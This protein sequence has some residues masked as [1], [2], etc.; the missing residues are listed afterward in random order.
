MT[1]GKQAVISNISAWQTW[2]LQ[3]NNTKWHKPNVCCTLP[4]ARVPFT[5]P[6]VISQNQGTLYQLS[7]CHNCY[8]LV[9]Q[10]EWLQACG[11]QHLPWSAQNVH[12][13]KLAAV[14]IVLFTPATLLYGNTVACL[15]CRCMQGAGMIDHLKQLAEP[16]GRLEVACDGQMSS[17]VRIKR[18]DSLRH[19]LLQ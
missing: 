16:H 18:T 19:Q 15:W 1:R 14:Q 17:H 6:N 13:S 5:V 9:G 10:Q 3:T 11:R 7:Y 4:A 2:S 12:Q 8:E